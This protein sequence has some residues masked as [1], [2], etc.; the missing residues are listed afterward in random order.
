VSRARI[1]VTSPL[2]GN[3]TPPLDIG[4]VQHCRTLERFGAQGV[5]LRNDFDVRHLLR[6]LKL[7]GLI[8]S[9]GGDVAPGAYGGDAVLA[10]SNDVDFRRDAFE[11]ALME[12][13][14]DA[15]LPILATCRGMEI[16]NV[17][18]GGTL[19]EDLHHHLGGAY[20]VMHHQVD[21]AGLPFYAYAHD[22]DITHGSLLYD[23][24]QSITLRVNSIHHQAIADLGSGLRAVAHAADGIIEA[25]EFVVPSSFFIG[26]Q[27]HPEWLSND[28][29]SE[30]LYA[31]LLSAATE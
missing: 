26:V 6:E 25:I 24:V 18:R 7:D 10:G 5:L 2:A 12:S 8:F 3:E 21:E 31:R 23:I 30:Q 20:T 11:F 9:G 14:L 15:E 28:S 29:A 13:A 1:G 22:V 27:W 16:M 19:I 17:L 4:A